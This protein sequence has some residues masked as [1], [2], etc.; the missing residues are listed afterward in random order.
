L[1]TVINMQ[2]TFLSAIL[3][4]MFTDLQSYFHWKTQQEICKNWHLEISPHLECVATLPCDLS[5][6]TTLVQECRLFSDT[7]D[8]AYKVV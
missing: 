5:L 2:S 8:L 4:P 3:P 6:I 7:D 1:L